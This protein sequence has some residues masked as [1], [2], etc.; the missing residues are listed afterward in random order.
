MSRAANDTK[1]RAA[2]EARG[3][4]FRPWEVRPEDVGDGPVPAWAKGSP[5]GNSW[6]LAQRLRRQL[7][8]AAKGKQT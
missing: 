6:T 3:L 5:W 2:C 7:L 8:A 4:R 1:V